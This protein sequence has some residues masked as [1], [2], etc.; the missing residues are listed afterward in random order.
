[1]KRAL[2]LTALACFLIPGVRAQ[3]PSYFS[4]EAAQQREELER[5]Q[6]EQDEREEDIAKNLFGHPPENADSEQLPVNNINQ[7]D[8]ARKQYWAA[9][10]EGDP[11]KILAA[12]KVFSDLLF[13][14]DLIALWTD[15]GARDKP[16]DRLMA[17]TLR[18][19]IPPGDEIPAS[20][21]EYFGKWS[22]DFHGDIRPPASQKGL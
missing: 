18:L 16:L 21:Q 15:P 14:R 1:M 5:Q 10:E 9:Y 2:L 4:M 3:Q 7:L 13:L 17:M 8:E 11:A 22:I 19:S 12:R 20:A 6:K